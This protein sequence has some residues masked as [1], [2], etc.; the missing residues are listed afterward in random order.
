LAV[1]RASA[2]LAGHI[3]RVD[4]GVAEEKV[5]R[6]HTG[7]VVAVMAN[8]RLA[9]INAVVDL[10]RATGG[11]ECFAATIETSIAV[12]GASTRPLPARP[13]VRVAGRDGTV[14]I[15]VAP[16]TLLPR[17]WFG[18]ATVR[19]W[20]DECAPITLLPPPTLLTM[21]LAAADIEIITRVRMTLRAVGLGALEGGSECGAISSAHNLGASHGLKMRWLAAIPL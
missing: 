4:F 1:L 9:R 3:F 18:A 19:L 2:P 21:S 7:R 10:P 8:I 11:L 14:L 20:W 17:Y 13:K 5:C 6:V 15:D 16:E 12:F